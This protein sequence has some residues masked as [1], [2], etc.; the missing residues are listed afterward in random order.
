MY[1][2]AVKDRVLPTIVNHNVA[3]AST[4]IEL[5]QQGY[6]LEDKKRIRFSWSNVLFD[7]FQNID[8]FNDEQQT[9]LENLYNKII[10]A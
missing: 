8:L 3:F 7:A 2:D 9:N 1:N 6:V 4:L 5:A 10:N